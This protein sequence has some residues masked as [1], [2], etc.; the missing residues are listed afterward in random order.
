MWSQLE[1]HMRKAAEHT[2]GR[3]DTQDI[4]EFVLNGSGQLWGAFL[5]DRVVGVLVTR[6][7]Q[8]P[9]KKCLDIVFLGG[10]DGFSWKDQMLEVLQRWAQDTGCEAIES[11]GR[12]GLIRAFKGSG[13]RPLWQV[14]EFPVM[15]G[16]GGYNG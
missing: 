9:R 5:D 10:D 8:Y 3:F 4:F 13:C 2:E 12:S 15:A 1:P 14:M 16:A 7:I 11:V 6:P